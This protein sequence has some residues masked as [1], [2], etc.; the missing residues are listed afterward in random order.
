[1]HE[2]NKLALSLKILKVVVPFFELA[3]NLYDSSGN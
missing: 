2:P 1:M 3:E